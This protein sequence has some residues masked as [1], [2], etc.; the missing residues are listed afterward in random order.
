MSVGFD[1]VVGATAP[2][3]SSAV[4]EYGFDAPGERPPACNLARSRTQIVVWNSSDE[5]A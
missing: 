5:G 1:F 3:T 4:L 2:G